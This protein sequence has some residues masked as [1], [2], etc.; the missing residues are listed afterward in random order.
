MLFSALVIVALGAE[1]RAQPPVDQAA[2][3]SAEFKSVKDKLPLGLRDTAACVSLLKR[4]RE[5]KPADQAKDA[6][7]ERIL[8]EIPEHPMRYRGV[9]LVVRGIARRV[10]SS[11]SSLAA[12]NRLLEVWITTP[13]KGPNPVACIVEEPPPGFPDRPVISEPVVIRGFFLKLMAYKVGEK[14]L[15]APLLIGRLE[16]IARQDLSV[17]DPPPD[18]V[19]VRL[20]EGAEARPVG[21]PAEEKLSLTLDRNGRLTIN[22]E[23]IAR[24]SLAKELEGL[25]ESIR[26]NVRAAGVL[27]P[28]DRE[29]PAALTLRAPAETPCTAVYKLMLDCQAYGFIKYS[30]ELA[31]D[32]PA[33]AEPANTSAPPRASKEN[34]LTDEQR[35][36][37]IWLRADHKGQIGQSQLGNQNLQG[38]DA[39]ERALTAILNDPNAPFDRAY[40]QLDP[41]LRYSEM[42]RVSRLL[43]H[44]TMTRIRFSLF[45]RGALAGC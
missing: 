43:Q 25:A 38:F 29:L 6:G 26:F 36:I 35:T 37:Q 19:F 32:D 33:K 42:V 9:R 39:L 44:P 24:R 17:I 18:D 22:G 34:N 16:H 15:V 4:A 12:G 31:N 11:Q 2:S 14:E 8:Q 27:L 21:P 7:S 41:R 40:V 45:S 1:L 3:K 5:I 10:F 23:A 13:G 20:P 28:R 30:L